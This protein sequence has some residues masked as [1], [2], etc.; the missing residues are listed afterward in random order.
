MTIKVLHLIDS[1]GLYGAEMVLLNLVEEQ[2]KAGLSPLILSAGTP[3]I[4]EKPLEKAA[5]ERGL[6]IKKWRMKAGFNL[7]EAWK[8]LKFAKQEGVQILHSH[9]YKFNLLMGI[10]PKSLRKIPLLSSLHGYVN[11]PQFTKMW[12][13]E[14]LDRKILNHIEGVFVVSGHMTENAS[15]KG[16]RKERLHIV[17]NG[18][19]IERHFCLDE[20]DNQN[21]EMFFNKYNKIIG[22]VGR[23]SK[24]KGIEYLIDAFSKIIEFEGNLGL[25]LIG[26]GPER[27]RLENQVLNL[28]IENQVLFAG[29][30]KGPHKYIKKIDCL[31][32]PS[33]TEG[34]PITLLETMWTGTPI[35]A[36]S[37]GG[38]PSVL[39]GGRYG[40]LVE[41][42]SVS[43]LVAALQAVLK[44]EPSE[45]LKV[46]ENARAR[47]RDSY[48]SKVMA[49]KYQEIYRMWIS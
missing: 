7:P 23:L 8:I 43:Q 27:V 28:G 44:Y 36:T 26:E 41:P 1:G 5:L 40:L 17:E 37:V 16:I 24:E 3:D 35:V 11:A 34:L 22:A 12:L 6:P 46:I 31:V 25:L 49:E 47:I 29:Y 39:D 9:G 10:W 20:E 15:I 30:I 14:L 13:Y 2:V 42:E 18:I 48:S 19:N 32:M 33:L 21:I 38:I 45:R 4:E